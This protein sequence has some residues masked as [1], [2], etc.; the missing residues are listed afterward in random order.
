MTTVLPVKGLRYSTAAGLDFPVI[1]TPPYDV[2]SNER[3]E[4][5]Y[6]KSP[7]NVIRLEYP[8]SLPGD[9]HNTNKYTRA[10]DTFREWIEKGILIEEEDPAFYLYEQHFSYHQ[11]KYIRR[12][13]FCGVGLSP[14]NEGNVIPHEE[15][16]TKPKADRLE[17][18]RHCETNFSPIFGLFKDKEMFVDSLTEEYKKNQKPVIDFQDE[19]GDHHLLWTVADKTF[20]EKIQSFFAHKKIYIADGHHRYETAL[21]FFEEKKEKD[22][23]PESYG[24]TLMGLVNIYDEG[25]LAFPTHR[26]VSQSSIQSIELINRLA[27]HFQLEE[28]PEP[29]NEEELQRLLGNSLTGA[30]DKN[31]SMGLYTPERKLFILTVKDLEKKPSP[32]L[33]IVVLQDLILSSIFKI[34]DAERKKESHLNYLRNEWEAKLQVD[35]GQARYVFFVNEPPFETIARLAED[36]IRMPQKSTYFFPKFLT[37]LVMLRLGT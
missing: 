23:D 29:E 26:I 3:Q 30:A 25:L 19:E 2:I 22:E 7:Y 27:E 36:G 1:I 18:L 20:V 4:E 14:F 12:G 15:T 8:K 10:A 24:H 31:L 9:D 32:W 5:F 35:Q 11:K 6:K 17:L 37:G 13:I 21:L 28:H 34:E 16:L 33:D